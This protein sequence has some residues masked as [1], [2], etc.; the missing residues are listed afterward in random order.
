[1]SSWLNEAAV[2]NHNGN[3]F[4]HINDP[5]AVAGAMM[6]PSGFMG[7]PAQFNAQFANPQQMVMPNGPMRNASPSFAN[8]MY[9]TNSVVPSKRPRPMEDGMSQSPRPAPGMLPTSR[10]ETPQQSAFPGFQQPGIS[11]QSTGQPSPYPHLQPNGSTNATPSPIMANQMRPGSI[12]QRVASSSPHPFSPAAQQFPQ[13]SPITS[14]HGG[15]PQAFMQQNTFPHS[16]NP[17]FTAAAQSPARPSPSPNP[18]AGQMMPQQMGQMQM[19]QF[20]QQ[21]QQLGP[22]AGQM[23]GQMPGQMAG[24]M[25]SGQMTGQLPGQTQGQMGGQMTGP[26]AGQMPNMMFPQQM[27][28]MGQMAQPR[29]ALEQQKLLYQMQLQQ[30]A[31]RTSMQM[32]QLGGG[33][34]M[35]QAQTNPNQ[36]QVQ[37]QPR[38]MMAARQ[39]APNGQM[40]PG[41][42]RPQQAGPQQPMMRM[43]PPEQFM[44]HLSAFMN[45]KGLPLDLH[46]VVDGRP[47]PLYNLFQIVYNKVGGYRN[48]TQSNSWIQVS[49]IMG[50]APHQIPSAAPQLK[51]VY[52]RNLLKFEEL[53]AAQQKMRLQQQ[54]G[55]ANAPGMPQQ[56]T[57]KAMPPGQVPPQM[58]QPGQPTQTQG[59]MQSPIKGPMP[60][61][62]GMN[63]LSASAQPPQ[64]Q[65]PILS[66]QGHSRNSLSRSVQA[67]PTADE[68]PL[69]SPAQSKAGIM[70][71]PGA[72]HPENQAMPDDAA[73]S[74]KFPA[75]FAT[76]PDEYMPSSRELTTY[77]GFDVGALWKIGDEL[78][79]AKIDVPLPIDFGN[80]DIHA[81]TK[82][83]QSG[84]HG[85]IRLAL[86]TL[87]SLT[88]SD[89]HFVS[90][91][92]P[93]PIPQIDLRHCDDLV[94][95]LIE[96]AEEQ[97][98][99]L[100][101]NSEEA[102]DEIT[103]TPYEEVVRACRVDRLRLS[104]VT[105]FGS[106]EYELDRAVD[107]L[108]CITTILRNL[109]CREE[110]HGPLADETVIQFLCVLIR[111]LGTRE[112]L[113]RT[114]P[115]TLDLMKDL[116]TLLSNISSAVEIPG[117]EQA[118]CLLQFLLAFAPTPGPTLAGGRLFFAP[119]EPALHPYLPHAVDSLAKLLARD[120]PNRTHYKAIF[121]AETA[122]ITSPPCELLTRT[123]ALAIS[124]VPDHMREQRAMNL[125]SLVE[126]RKPLLMQ[127]LLS[128]D[129]MGGLAPGHESGVTRLWLT[130]GNGFAQN[131]FLLAR[132]LGSQFEGPPA[133]T[134]RGQPVGQPKRDPDLVYIIGLA[135]S[136]L[137]RLTEKALDPSDPAGESSI[138][139][140]VLPA[141]ESVLEAL[142]M[143]AQEWAKDGILANLVEYASMAEKSLRLRG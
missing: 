31:Q 96:C 109:S 53:W 131:L 105:V 38:N 115:N 6:D 7:N 104:K 30:Q 67:T 102:S 70:S 139:P 77:G 95:A 130:S 37:G 133:R 121:A 126:A 56:G 97:M 110:N 5:S 44:K 64:G 79:R 12:P 13:A 89:Y 141:K 48:T 26:M 123:F 66:S 20:P 16:F 140:E 18:M 120:E 32:Q 24:Q 117:R 142:Q 127:S 25:M 81:L 63:G 99:L 143:Q 59:Q 132:H 69:A 101:E 88:S 62:P 136:L 35:M 75:P 43:P 73:S 15:T 138:P 3:G 111:Y 61:Q 90:P 21:M 82:S 50:F 29:N 41:G 57:P 8:P 10:A 72:A 83:I 17:Q 42:M 65:Q 47:I 71:L 78:Q 119:Y 27:G 135:L 40:V 74:L 39:G 80:V 85:E 100:V 125:P 28:Q 128:A 76:N 112:M 14:D 137:R 58:M 36:T 124:P 91:T 51:G 114:N 92:Q 98:D 113:L 19:G 33:Q 84:I 106:Q 60:Q 52:E 122:V 118:F 1:M 87:A 45:S 129:I 22:L 93:I 68:F 23:P 103:I 107:R 2:P 94:D 46:P 116:V 34:N 9:Q 4:P 55:M 134:S 49:Q 11:Q 86:D 108:I 54:G